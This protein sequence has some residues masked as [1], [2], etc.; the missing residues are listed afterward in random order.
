MFDRPFSIVGGS[1]RYP[2]RA[3]A[4]LSDPTRIDLAWRHYRDAVPR[5]RIERIAARIESRASTLA[6]TDAVDLA[7]RCER[8]RP[9]LSGARIDDDAAMEAISLVAV[10]AKQAID[11]RPTSPRIRAC[12]ALLAGSVVDVR[13][14][15][16]DTPEVI[17][18]AAAT[19]G[20]A[21]LPA[22]VISLNA[23]QS[24][25]DFERMA[26]LYRALRIPVARV[27]ASM[28]DDDRRDAYRA[29]VVYCD[30]R[31]LILDYL[32]D[33]RSLKGRARIRQRFRALGNEAP[34]SGE[35]FLPGLVCGLVADADAILVDAAD[36]D[37]SIRHQE[38]SYDDRRLL[39]AAVNVASRLGEI[40]DYRWRD[41]AA[42]VEL[43]STGK[44]RMNSMALELGGL[45]YRPY[46]REEIVRAA[47]IALFACKRG[48]HY[49]VEDGAIRLSTGFID[50][51]SRDD[52]RQRDVTQLLAIKEGCD[53]R[54]SDDEA[55]ISYRRFF[56]RYCRLSGTSPVASHVG[57]ELSSLFDFGTYRV[58]S[59]RE[60]RHGTAGSAVFATAQRKW[61]AVVD[62]VRETARD[63][64]PAIILCQTPDGAKQLADSFQ[65]NG[66]DAQVIAGQDFATDAGK[67]AICGQ[68][69]MVSILSGQATNGLSRGISGTRIHVIAAELCDQRQRIK[70]VAGCGEGLSDLQQMVS[71][72][73]P[74]LASTMSRIE[75]WLIPHLAK[76]R[77]GLNMFIVDTWLRFR[78]RRIEKIKIR[79][80]REL[81]LF[82]DRLDRQL[83]FSSDA[84]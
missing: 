51:T 70:L 6:D 81:Q 55:T 3:E 79:S 38:V 61:S 73:E 23:H 25:R 14:I 39:G 84:G 29:S 32:R 5:R 45:W 8:L 40:A 82:S 76:K 49:S 74:F 18:L 42:D 50:A 58:T 27:D 36:E 72:D 47:I 34:T 26:P 78:A 4:G 54:A 57:R 59:R 15:P 65:D 53:L 75:R 43:T 33:Q 12:L 69:G 77:G 68:P 30:C 52:Q 48:V 35:L 17:G 64:R 13:E 56:R 60:V 7:R 71:L 22:Q 28:A 41:N 24:G 63:R 9:G 62:V 67:L 19:I 80:R 10:A 16:G 44:R 2:Q 83:T 31:Q 37:V 11:F 21:G 46:R 1:D 66:I 20:L